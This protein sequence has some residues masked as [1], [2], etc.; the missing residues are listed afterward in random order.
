[1]ASMQ[2]GAINLDVPDDWED[3]SV[4]T[5]V[6]RPK[7]MAGVRDLTRNLMISRAPADGT[8]DG[9]AL[10]E[11]QM[12]SLKA[13]L[14]DLEVVDEGTLEIG[15]HS[16]RTR[17]IRFSTPEKGLVQQ[18]HVHV[19]HGAYAYTIVG[20]GSAG[21]AFDGLRKDLLKIVS[22]FSVE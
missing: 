6:K 13:A 7:A 11:I 16:A 18:L 14:D 8:F 17:E 5:L 9:D 1:M 12:E 22:S 2:F 4:I 21:L 3:Q 15:E 19:L 10:A 20:T